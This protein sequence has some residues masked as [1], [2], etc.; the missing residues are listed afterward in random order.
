MQLRKNERPMSKKQQELSQP[1]E[2]MLL[3]MVGGTKV[4]SCAYFKDDKNT[5]DQAQEAKLDYVL[6]K[7][8]L[9]ADEDFL[10]VGCGWGALVIRAAARF[11]AVATG[12]TISVSQQRAAEEQIAFLKLKSRATIRVGDFMNIGKRNRYDKVASVAMFEHVGRKNLA[13]YFERAHT[14]LRPGGLFLNH[15]MA[16]QN[17]RPRE[18]GAGVVRA[19]PG[20]ELV[21]VPEALTIATKAG[22]EIR[23]VENLREHYAQTF[24]LWADNLEKESKEIMKEVGANVYKSTHGQMRKMSDRFATGELAL[25]HL[26]L[27]KPGRRGAANIPKTRADLYA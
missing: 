12:L 8:R 10:D 21:T 19:F 20:A 15:G 18:R 24:A 9:K 6:R 2:R 5:L 1:I 11:G 27:A 23:D 3:S 7:L 25:F 13:D 16:L 22:F 4:F 14:M 17:H 26:L